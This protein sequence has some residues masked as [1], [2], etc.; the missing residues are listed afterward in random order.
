MNTVTLQLV[1][2]VPGELSP[3]ILYVSEEYAVAVHLCACGCGN[4][5][6][7]PLGPAE[8]AFSERRG[9]PT[10]RPS[11]GNWQIP[12]RS[13]YLI[14]DGQIEWAT[15]WSDAQIA[16]GRLAEEQRRRAYYAAKNRERGFWARFWKFVRKLFRY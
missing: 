15:Q 10:L 4:K 9:F 3:G 13:H 5:V 14:T 11:I 8:W 1:K 2:Y 7:T 16:A 12:C 6:T